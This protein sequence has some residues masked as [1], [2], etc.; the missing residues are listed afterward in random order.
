MAASSNKPETGLGQPGMKARLKP[1][2]PVAQADNQAARFVVNG[3]P[4]AP[5]GDAAFG[6]LPQADLGQQAV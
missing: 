4:M 6:V 5:V 1:G 3:V 2:L